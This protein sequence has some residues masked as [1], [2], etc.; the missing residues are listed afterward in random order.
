MNENKLKIIQSI[1]IFT[2]NAL[3]ANSRGSNNPPVKKLLSDFFD[4]PNGYGSDPA[5]TSGSSLI[6]P[7]HEL[8][9]QLLY[10]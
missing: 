1:L 5:T 9:H 4:K 6:S 2:H 10:F 7:I 8:Q 3:F